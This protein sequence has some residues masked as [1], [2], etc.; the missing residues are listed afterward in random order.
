LVRDN[1]HAAD[2]LRE[3]QATQNDK[4]ERRAKKRILSLSHRERFLTFGSTANALPQTHTHHGGEHTWAQSILHAH[5]AVFPTVREPIH[6]RGR[7]SGDILQSIRDYG[8]VR[9]RDARQ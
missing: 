6:R 1:H 4:R 9:C 2:S 8:S 3:T 7:P 5:G